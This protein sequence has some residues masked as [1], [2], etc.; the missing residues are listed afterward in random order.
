M[1]GIPKGG[2]HLLSVHNLSGLFLFP[3]APG[4]CPVARLPPLL[5]APR[6]R[7]PSG[8]GRRRQLRSPPHPAPVPWGAPSGKAGGAGGAGGGLGSSLL[9]P[10]PPFLIRAGEDPV[11]GL[12]EPPSGHRGAEPRV[13]SRGRRSPQAWPPQRRRGAAPCPA[14]SRSSPPSPTCSSSW[15]S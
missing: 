8:S 6:A 12:P 15:S 5:P 11:I 4:L 7:P 10:A 14:A 13:P 1:V 2:D 9:R 3:V